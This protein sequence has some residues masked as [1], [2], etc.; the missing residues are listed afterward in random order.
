MIYI[1]KDGNAININPERMVS[2]FTPDVGAGTVYM[3]DIL[4][5]QNSIAVEE[6]AGDRKMAIKFIR[7]LSI[8]QVAGGADCADFEEFQ[9]FIKE[10]EEEDE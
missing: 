6:F 3:T 1:N 2:L 9:E 4:Y 8:E 7:W 5:M 10:E